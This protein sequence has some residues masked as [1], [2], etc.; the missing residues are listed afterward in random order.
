M[1]TL[2]RAHR[3]SFPARYDIFI[4][5]AAQG[6]VAARTLRHGGAIVVD[7]QRYDFISSAFGRQ[8]DLQS[9]TGRTVAT[10]HREGPTGWR[11]ES[12][13]HTY[14]LSREPKTR[15]IQVIDES[16]HKIGYVRRPYL[17]KRYFEAELS[18][19]LDHPIA[20]F[21]LCITLATSQRRRRT[22]IVAR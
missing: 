21:V 20:V 1:N 22:V 19:A 17:S 14:Y 5:D 6:T 8:Y 10:A 12:Y 18:G 9:A 16:S 13:G 3:T 4:D 11:I 15:T 2:L 7:E